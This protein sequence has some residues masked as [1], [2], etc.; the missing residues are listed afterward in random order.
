MVNSY[1]RD[2]IRA[3]QL[4]QQALPLVAE[5]NDKPAAGQFYMDLANQLMGNRGWSLAWR[6]QYLSDLTELPDYDEGYYG[7]WYYHGRGQTRGAPVDEKGK[8]VYHKLPRS[9]ESAATDGE[10]WR[11]ALLMVQEAQASR[12]NEV[13][14]LFAQFLHH[15]FGVQT[16]S[17]YGMMLGRAGA[18]SDTEKDESGT[19]ALH[20]LGEGA[21]QAAR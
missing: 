19:Y 8:P 10:R 17:Q 16:M 20:T 9:W 21:L 18:D 7:G 15:Q 13:R 11:W 12:T 3:L 4:M 2:R 5:E 14:W 6:L 1:E